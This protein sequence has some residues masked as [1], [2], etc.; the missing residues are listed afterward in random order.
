MLQQRLEPLG[1]IWSRRLS[2][3]RDGHRQRSADSQPHPLHRQIPFLARERRGQLT[4]RLTCP[5]PADSS[6]SQVVPMFSVLNEP[7]METIGS[8]ALRS[9]YVNCDSLLHSSPPD[10]LPICSYFEA[11]R[12]VRAASGL[13]EGH[14]PVSFLSTLALASRSTTQLSCSPLIDDHLPRRLQGHSALV[15]LPPRCRPSGLRL[16]S[17][18]RLPRAQPRLDGSSSAQALHQLGNRL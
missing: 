12:T 4:A 3:R 8:F 9:L 17:L 16:A 2:Q 5:A 18:P 14:G 1:Q 6:L 10:R 11:Y 15:R 13:G 7:F